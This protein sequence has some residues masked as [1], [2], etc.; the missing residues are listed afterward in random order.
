MYKISILMNVGQTVQVIILTALH[1][2]NIGR[3]M[4][5]EIQTSKEKP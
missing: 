2:R 1:R 3:H 5:T 4:L